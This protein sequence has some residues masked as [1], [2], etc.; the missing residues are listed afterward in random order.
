[1]TEK[2]GQD[3]PDLPP[4]YAPLHLLLYTWHLE[5][6]SLLLNVLRDSGSLDTRRGMKQLKLRV[7]KSQQVYPL[8]SGSVLTPTM[9]N[10]E[11]IQPA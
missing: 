6:G 2:R 9:N 5:G 3:E 8:K 4:F 10:L 1:M 11:T 7:P